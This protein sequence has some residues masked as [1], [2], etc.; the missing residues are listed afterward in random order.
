MLRETITIQNKTG[1]HARPAGVL[2][3]SCST[4]HSVIE[5]NYHGNVIKAKSIM[6]ILRAGIRYNDQIELICTGED[7]IE[8]MN[9]LKKLFA[10]GFGFD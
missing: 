6:A 10:K 1:L 9:T 2:A 5:L 8:A 3:K 4:F 7:E